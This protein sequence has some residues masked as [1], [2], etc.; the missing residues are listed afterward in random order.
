M[1]EVSQRLKLFLEA[2]E[3]NARGSQSRF[4][5]NLGCA[6]AQVTYW[7]KGKTLP[8]KDYVNK[9]VEVYNL[10]DTWLFTGE[11]E[12]FI[13]SKPE[14]FTAADGF[15]DVSIPCIN[16][17]DP[18]MDYAVCVASLKEEKS[19][20]N[21]EID[22]TM[23]RLLHRLPLRNEYLLQLPEAI[24]ETSFKKN[25][26]VTIVKKNS[27]NIK[28]GDVIL[29]KDSDSWHLS[30][31]VMIENS[32]LVFVNSEDV[33][34]ESFEEVYSI[35]TMG[36]NPSDDFPLSKDDRRRINKRISDYNKNI[37]LKA[38]KPVVLSSAL[39]AMMLLFV[40][41][42]VLTLF[43]FGV[44]ETTTKLITTCAG[45]G[46]AAAITVLGDRY[47]NPFVDALT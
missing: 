15:E 38:S 25:E 20:W 16:E 40:T 42:S 13:T 22:K 27:A 18:R 17:T 35:H 4:S 14:Y 9:M 5:E 26:F 44:S 43:S 11:G 47:Y 2:V 36:Q 28:N 41:V 8:G 33:L 31:T 3:G 1:N 10:N 19:G 6:R 46:V 21:L 30:A 37:S 12:M 7:L 34:F 32:F 39:I 29:F 24:L 45:M 23:F